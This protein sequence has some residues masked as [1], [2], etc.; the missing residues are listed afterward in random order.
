[1]DASNFQNSTQFQ[2]P[3]GTE[4]KRMKKRDKNRFVINF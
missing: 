4:S 1:M 2:T 3:V